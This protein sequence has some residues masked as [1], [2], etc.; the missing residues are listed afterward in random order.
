MQRSGENDYNI[1]LFLCANRW[2]HY[3]V[4]ITDA[5]RATSGSIAHENFRISVEENKASLSFP[6]S[7][8]GVEA[9]E[10][11]IISSTINSPE[12]PPK[13]GNPSS[14][15]ETFVPSLGVKAASLSTQPPLAIAPFTPEEAKQ[16]QQAVGRPSRCAC[17]VRE[18]YRHEDGFD[19]AR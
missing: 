14:K 11:W 10:W 5:A 16:H 2:G 7:Y 3:F 4:P 9:F 12:W 15:I 18:L 1:H 19:P 13:T 8:L 17:R 6:E